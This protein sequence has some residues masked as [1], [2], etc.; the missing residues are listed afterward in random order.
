MIQTTLPNL[1]LVLLVPFSTLIKQEKLVQSR[2]SQP[3]LQIRP[4]KIYSIQ[5]ENEKQELNKPS[6]VDEALHYPAKLR[7]L[8]RTFGNN[9]VSEVN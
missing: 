8:K 6:F 7:K 2:N 9:Q 5:F 1:I 4:G 3:T